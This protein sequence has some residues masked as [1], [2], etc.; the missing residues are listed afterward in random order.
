MRKFMI[1]CLAGFGTLSLVAMLAA[2]GAVGVKVWHDHGGCGVLSREFHVDLDETAAPR[3][4]ALAREAKAYEHAA[5]ELREGLRRIDRAGTAAA[6]ET[7]GLDEARRDVRTRLEAALAAVE[8]AR[9]ATGVVSP[10][11]C[12]EPRATATRTV[13]APPAPRA[14]SAEPAPAPKRDPRAFD[15]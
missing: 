4:V 14:A 3:P 5:R 11:C 7:P 12:G 6:E 1:V 13:P 8:A 15:F 2:A 9:A 10:G